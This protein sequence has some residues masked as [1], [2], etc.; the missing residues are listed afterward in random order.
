M[1]LCGDFPFEMYHDPSDVERILQ[2]SVKESAAW[3]SV[4][5]HAKNFV[6]GLLVFDPELR[7]CHGNCLRHV[8][9]TGEDGDEEG[10]NA[11]MA[12]VISPTG[13]TVSK[14][15]EVPAHAGAVEKVTGW[16]GAAV[17]SLQLHWRD[18][19]K[20]PHGGLGGFEKLV[21]NLSPG[22]IVI[23]VMQ[24]TRD[25]YP[26]SLG[27]AI[28]LYTSFSQVLAFQGSD[29]WKRNR[30]VAPVG[31][32]I[33]GLQFVGP[34]LCGIHLESS[35]GN[36]GAVACITGHTGY[37]VDQI[38]FELRDGS[39]RQ[40]GSDGGFEQGP[41]SLAEN[42]YITIVEQSCRD[43]YLG[44]SI[45]FYTSAGN[46]CK[47]SGMSSSLS[48]RFSAPSGTQI[49]SLEFDG[50]HLMCVRTCPAHVCTP[51]PGQMDLR[52]LV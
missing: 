39:A 32:Q 4:S 24:E 14:L 17:D 46:I 45:A 19:S 52:S 31:S 36:R 41:W 10:R 2:Q 37:G 21:Y 30:F 7:L 34:A 44:N 50:S 40:Y 43:E 49:C 27:N 23:G 51:E 5:S 28:V 20:H 16:V 25:V 35:I 3:Q 26:E 48:R 33:V 29:A 47:L 9:M 42:E 15:S 22:E 38:H 11:P 18:G 6:C 13:S 12:Q 8:W 1:M